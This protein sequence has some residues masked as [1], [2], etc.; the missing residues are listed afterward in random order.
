MTKKHFD[1]EELVKIA[2]LSSLELNDEEITLF[3]SQLE[4]L[5]TYVDELAEVAIVDG[6]D[7]VR[8]INVFREDRAVMIDSAPLLAQAPAKEGTSIVVPKILD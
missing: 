1:Q 7:V 5:L 6:V 4:V 8:N 2:H 3:G